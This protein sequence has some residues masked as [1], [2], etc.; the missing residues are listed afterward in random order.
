MGAMIEGNQRLSLIQH[1]LEMGRYEKVIDLAREGLAERPDDGYLHYIMALSYYQLEDY[2]DSEDHL[3]EAAAHGFDSEYIASLRGDLFLSTEQWKESEY[4]YLEALRENPLNAS[5]HASYGYLMMKTGHDKKGKQL[6]HKA[7]ELE[8]D[9]PHVLR[10]VH[11]F[12][13]AKDN[14]EEQLLALER[15]IHTSDDEVSKL[16]QMG[17]N[18]LYNGKEKAAREHF[19][20]AFILQPTNQSLRELLAAFESDHHWLLLPH[21]FVNKIGGPV[22]LYVGGLGSIFGTAALGWNTVSNVLLVSY[23]AYV[24]YSWSAIGIVKLI[25]KIRG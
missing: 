17:L 13:L 15:Y 8:P 25:Q 10:Y 23:L 3:N 22:V 16:I 14:Q 24:V 1:Y 5:I 7:L 4:W 6:L 11:L 21:R 19:R 18:E 9:N 2:Q 12:K 20:Q